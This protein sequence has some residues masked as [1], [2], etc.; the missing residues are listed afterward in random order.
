MCIDQSLPLKDSRTAPLLPSFISI[1]KHF[2]CAAL[3]FELK[4]LRSEDTIAL[5]MRNWNVVLSP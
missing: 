4:L 3:P 2:N 1:D 5:A